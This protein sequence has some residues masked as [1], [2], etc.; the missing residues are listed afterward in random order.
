MGELQAAS[1]CDASLKRMRGLLIFLAT[2]VIA[3]V[4]ASHPA[5]SGGRPGTAKSATSSKPA[6]P[7]ALMTDD[8]KII[9]A[10]G[11][12][13]HRSLGQFSLTPAELQIVKRAID[14]SEA[15]KPVEDLQAW[16]PK[17][18]A[19]AQGR[20]KIASQQVLDKAAAEPGATKTPSG[21]IF[22]ELT[23]GNGASPQPTDTVKVNYRGTLPDGNEF[24]SSYA[25]NAPAQF[26][27]NGVIPCWT[28]GLQKMKVGG[29]AKLVCPSSLAYGDQGRPGIPPGA[30]LTF[31]VELLEV[32]NGAPPAPQP[33]PPPR[34]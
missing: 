21:L 19:F 1:R 9:Y 11:L 26:A 3:Q 18:G 29:K 13:I 4:P 2:G 22:R 6:A 14:D 27:L 16:G 28:E 33:P 30:T 32:V 31:E 8:Q 25:R 23:P 15:G 20:Q 24:D 17:I 10:L 7:P 12:S 34:Q 5:A